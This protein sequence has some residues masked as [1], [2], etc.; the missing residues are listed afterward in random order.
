MASNMMARRRLLTSLLLLSVRGG[1]GRG[2]K[3]ERERKRERERD[4]HGYLHHVNV[5]LQ[6]LSSRGT[7]KFLLNSELG[8]GASLCSF[9]HLDD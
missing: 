6:T 7:V 2:E 8:G 4:D 1:E 3:E 9:I 5:H